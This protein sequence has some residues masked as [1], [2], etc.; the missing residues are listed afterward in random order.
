MEWIILEISSVLVNGRKTVKYEKITC[1]CD[2]CKYGVQKLKC[3]YKTGINK[4]YKN[5]EYRD[6]KIKEN[7]YEECREV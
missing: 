6:F 1:V 4:C 3:C 2:L 7:R 5:G